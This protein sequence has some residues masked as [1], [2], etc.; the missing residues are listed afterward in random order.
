MRVREREREHVHLVVMKD[1]LRCLQ[2]SV[3][4][5]TKS[6]SS[7]NTLKTLLQQCA[8]RP[9]GNAARLS[10]SRGSLVP[11]TCVRV[12][13]ASLCLFLALF[14]SSSSV[15]SSNQDIM[16]AKRGCVSTLRAA[17]CSE[18]C[19]GSDLCRHGE[20][21]HGLDDRDVTGNAGRK[22][23]WPRRL[24]QCARP[25][26]SRHALKPPC[27]LQRRTEEAFSVCTSASVRP[28]PHPSS[29]HSAPR[30]PPYRNLAHP[31]SS[32]SRAPAA[33]APRHAP[34]PAAAGAAS[35]HCAFACLFVCASLFHPGPGRS[36]YKVHEC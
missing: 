34:R 36:I 13:G 33:P 16:R 7:Q 28:C 32:C 25:F 19:E 5:A 9:R 8:H 12:R 30:L 27:V 35:D 3:G 15:A 2:I 10:L 26:P 6:N 11:S 24:C 22:S 20:R 23:F 31:G 14:P 21:R 1:E 4:M 29:R 18:R 17:G